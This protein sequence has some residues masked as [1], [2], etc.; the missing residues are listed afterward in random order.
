MTDLTLLIANL[1]V[2]EGKKRRGYDDANDNIL[3]KGYT[4]IGTPTVGVGHNLEVPLSQ[5]AIKQILLDDIA[6][7]VAAAQS[8]G[9]FQALNTPRQLAII[10]M[11]F[12]LG[13]A[14]FDE[15]GTFIG[16]L[17]SG[18]YIS[19]A[20]DLTTTLWYKQVGQRAVRIASIISTGIWQKA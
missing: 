16:L 5:A 3:T 4:I 20:N 15:F 13:D 8:H 19:A 10:D 1:L 14:G 7:A 6:P 9:W 18:M 12:N 17:K 2:E 11:I